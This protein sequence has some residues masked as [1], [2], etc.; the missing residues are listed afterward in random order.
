MRERG[1]HRDLAQKVGQ[2]LVDI[3][4]ARMNPRESLQGEDGSPVIRTLD[5]F[6]KELELTQ[7][8]KNCLH[9]FPQDP[10][11]VPKNDCQTPQ[12]VSQSKHQSQR[13][14]R[15]GDQCSH[16]CHQ[17]TCWEQQEPAQS[18]DQHRRGFFRG[19]RE[20]PG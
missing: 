11:F 19:H 9:H 10:G 13:F 16:D 7:S 5:S 12:M 14:Q 2:P 4:N 18:C 17:S 20:E 6:N 3:V 8:Y 15:Q 1:S